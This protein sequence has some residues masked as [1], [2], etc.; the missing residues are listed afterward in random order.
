MDPRFAPARK[1]AE[2]ARN[3]KADVDLEELQAALAAPAAAPSP[4]GS[5]LPRVTGDVP[6][7]S[8]P[9]SPSASGGLEDLSLDSLSLDGP[10][11]DFTAPAPAGEFPLPFEPVA[12]ALSPEP[13][14]PD[15]SQGALADDPELAYRAPA[16]MEEEIAALLKKGDEARSRGDR[17]QD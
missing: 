4:S 17:Q 13:A 9:A 14:M 1:L 12:P 16:S 6:L 2:K 15:L 3:P 8:G 11:S 10:V 7:V 5:P